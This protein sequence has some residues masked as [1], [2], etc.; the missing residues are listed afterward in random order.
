MSASRVREV[1]ERW[2]RQTWESESPMRIMS[3]VRGG[4]GVM[5]VGVGLGGDDEDVDEAGDAEGDGD[6]G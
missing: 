2:P 4:W 6:E 5:G 1:V 3:I